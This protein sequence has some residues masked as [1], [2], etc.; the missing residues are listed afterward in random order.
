MKT[1]KTTAQLADDLAVKIEAAIPTASLASL[2]RFVLID[3]FECHV[4]VTLCSRSRDVTHLHCRQWTI[5]SQLAG[6]RCSKWSANT[7]S[8]DCK[9]C[10]QHVPCCLVT[11]KFELIYIGYVVVVVI[12]CAYFII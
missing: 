1:P 11:T 7:H 6:R 5:G 10:G 2:D 9:Q 12:V 3:A 4:T 8:A